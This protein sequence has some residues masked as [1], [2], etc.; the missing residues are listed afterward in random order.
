MDRKKEKELK[1]YPQPISLESTEKIINQMKNNI[2]K[3]V[4]GDG[5]KGTGFF[6]KIPFP[7]NNYLIP[8]LIT[9]SHIITR[10]ILEKK[11]K[12][13][14]FINN[15]EEK[16]EILI[17]NRKYYTNEEYDITIIELKEIDKINNYL[18]IE[19]KIKYNELYINETIYI[20]QYPG[21]KTVSV[22]YGLIKEID[23]KKE[24]YFNHLCSTD[25]GSSGS[26]VLNMNNKVI[27]I[28][29]EANTKFNYNIG[30]F[31]NYSIKDFINEEFKNKEIK[32][33][34][35][36]FNLNIKDNN[37]IKLDL[38]FKSIKEIDLEILE[39]ANFKELKELDLSHNKI[40][41]IKVLE[42]VKFEK[43]EILNLIKN[44]LSDINIL[45]K[46]NFK[47]LKVLFLSYN[48][49][50][51]IRVLEKVKFE[52]L[53]ILNL[54]MNN[55]SDINI[56]EKVNFK[57]LKELHLSLN[58]ISDIKV[59]EKVKFEKLEIINLKYNN[60]SDINTLEKIN[61]K[62]LK[63]FNLSN[64]KISDIKILEKV[65]FEKLEKLYLSE[66]NISESLY[67]PTISIL[68]TK[69]KEFNV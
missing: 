3:I 68:K 24:Y 33:L 61:F 53:E 18:E 42:K 2:C 47:E 56:L 37:I 69:I 7:D 32:G 10:E 36:Q 25:D 26:P 12:I 62:E 38:S 45:E 22:S 35:N 27:G 52:K 30:S 4:I 57:E 49:I 40:S 23:L 66:N 16:K 46:V 21:D 59:L 14:I 50:S 65:K 20:L 1:D 19:E 17:E 29:K 43:L 11:E 64:N 58:K 54:S 55:I 9:N 63:E 5:S 8:V 28:H 48:K 34:N 41:D 67:S 51:D 39:N 60:I 13:T 6:S 15:G 31:L 44:N